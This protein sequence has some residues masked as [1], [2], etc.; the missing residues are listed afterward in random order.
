M[1]K[2]SIFLIGCLSLVV[3][4]VITGFALTYSSKPTPPILPTPTAY[5]PET[6]GLD[7]A[8][9]AAKKIY[10]SREFLIYIRNSLN[11]DLGVSKDYFE[12][13]IFENDSA[14]G[15]KCNKI[16]GLVDPPNLPSK[17]NPYQILQ[18]DG[19]LYVLIVDQ[20]GAGSGE[21]IA[22]ILKSTDGGVQWSLTSCFYFGNPDNHSS[23]EYLLTNAPQK[24]KG[25]ECNNFVL[26][27]G[28]LVR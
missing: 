6:C 4:L 25:S 19:S 12:S 17:N 10:G 2:R 1:P 26:S 11:F 7:D 27:A 21:G 5:I 16:L 20:Y 22:K 9:I 15:L 3:T 14:S 8:Q 18:K 13:G 23:L 24:V 28:E